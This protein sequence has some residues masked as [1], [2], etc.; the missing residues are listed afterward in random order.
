MVQDAWF[1][2]LIPDSMLHLRNMNIDK[3]EA[4]HLTIIT[5]PM[6]SG[7]TSYLIRILETS[8]HV[9]KS[10]YI[11]SA[12]DTRSDAPY[13]THNSI[14]KENLHEKINADMLTVRNLR[15]VPDEVLNDYPVVCVDEAQ[16][17][18]D[19]VESVTHMV[20]D[21]HKCVYVAGLSGDFERKPF[22]D[23]Y[24]LYPHADEV[25]ML[26]DTFCATCALKGKRTEALFT[27]KIGGHDS[28]IEIGGSSLYVAVCR[29]CYL[30]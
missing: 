13:S 10:L 9:A 21:L 27:K 25:I 24:K 12:C 22:G 20:D 17:F 19:L 4:G 5:G 3:M 18:V 28:L 7:K 15:D 30:D 2:W 26:R 23:I 14:L 16:F 1:D 29:K 8:G 11:N 6:F